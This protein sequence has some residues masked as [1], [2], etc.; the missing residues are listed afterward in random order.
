MLLLRQVKTIMVHDRFSSSLKEAVAFACDI[1]NQRRIHITHTPLKELFC[2]FEHCYSLSQC[3]VT[4]MLKM[5]CIELY[6][7]LLHF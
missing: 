4:Y 1:C 7:F 5:Y 3:K 6:L 2:K